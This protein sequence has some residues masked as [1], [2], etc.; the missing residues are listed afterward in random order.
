MAKGITH[1]SK[2]TSIKENY[3]VFQS[4]EKQGV[5]IRKHLLPRSLVI[6]EHLDIPI[7]QKREFI[8]A[9]YEALPIL[10]SQAD[11]EIVVAAQGLVSFGH[12]SKEDDEFHFVT[13]GIEQ[14]FQEVL[15]LPHFRAVRQ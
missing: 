7:H 4:L 12:G 15:Q 9:V 14:T 8:N 13:S 11:Q 3:P 2:R 10:S 1:G 6:R 5:E